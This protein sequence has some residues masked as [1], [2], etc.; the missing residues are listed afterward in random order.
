MLSLS[1]FACFTSLTNLLS[2]TPPPSVPSTFLPLQHTHTQTQSN[3]WSPDA[4][5]SW[6]WTLLWACT[7]FWRR[8]SLNQRIVPIAKLWMK[9]KFARPTKCYQ[10]RSWIFTNWQ[11]FYCY[12][13][14]I[15]TNT[16]CVYWYVHFCYFM[17][18]VCFKAHFG[19]LTTTC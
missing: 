5:G 13:V 17:F 12:S 7:I 1:K 9:A 16:V 6:L 14:F 10:V 8:C 11:I 4:T 19:V 2:P 18:F 15:L 3:G